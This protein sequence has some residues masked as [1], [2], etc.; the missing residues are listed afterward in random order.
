MRFGVHC[1]L[2]TR[3]WT[4]ADLD[5]LEHAKELGFA[6]L[7][8]S[9]G[10]LENIEPPKIRARAEK[11]GIEV[12]SALGL[13]R[14]YALETPDA[15]TRRRT[16]EFLKT[17]VSALR[18]MGGRLFGG[19]FYAVP[20]R[21]SGTGPTADELSWLAEGIREV[22]VFARGCGVSLAIEPVNRYETYLL[23]TAA[24][25]HALIDRIDEPNLGLLLDTYHMNIEERG[26]AATIIRH[27][28][29]L[30]HLH[31]NESDRGTLG[32]GNIEWPSI[33]SALEQIRYTGMASIEV[34]GTPSPQ[35]P[36]ITPIWRK[37][38]PSPDQMAKDGLAFLSKH[39]TR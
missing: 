12:I 2:W 39:A 32:G 20:G 33:F 27:A 36:A 30:R 23:N 31:L 11:V 16:V 34:F 28:A 1:R 3:A 26:M 4:S 15:D 38:F 35:S 29:K 6:A 5:L 13:S 19:M 21:F 25:A 7:E 22:A 8:I 10:N 14:E 9:L 18:D 37:L 24:D 17:A